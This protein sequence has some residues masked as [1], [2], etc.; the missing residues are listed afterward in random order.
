MHS[1][2]IDAPKRERWKRAYLEDGRDVITVAV[3]DVGIAAMTIARVGA[4][5]V[6]LIK[7]KSNFRPPGDREERG[8]YVC[9]SVSTGVYRYRNGVIKS[10]PKRRE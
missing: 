9:L 5:T 7:A 3:S 4:G 1:T 8:K 10:T 6:A 2:S